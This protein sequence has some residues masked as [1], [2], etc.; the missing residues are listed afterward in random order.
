MQQDRYPRSYFR[1][2]FICQYPPVS[3]QLV[4]CKCRDDTVISVALP[5]PP[6]LFHDA[7]GLL[8]EL[9][10]LGFPAVS[11]RNKATQPDHMIF[12]KEY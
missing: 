9:S 10:A 12:W 8:G 4:S 3:T 2:E 11:P 1:Q 5:K 7:L 6:G